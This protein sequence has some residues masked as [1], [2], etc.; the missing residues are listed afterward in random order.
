MTVIDRFSRW[1]EAVPLASATAADCAKA[2]LR[3]WVSR[4]GT[5]HDITTDQGPQFTSSLWTE[6]MSLLGIKALRTTSYHPQCNGMVERVH[7]VLKERLM[8][9]AASPSDWMQDLP[10]V[11]LGLRTS[12][13][14]DSTF[15]P[16][17]LVYGSPLRLPGEFFEPGNP[18]EVK[19]SDF[20]VQL[21]RSLKD[22]TPSK[23]EFHSSRPCGAAGVP[24][25]LTAS[26]SVFVRVDAVKRPLTPPYIG[27]FKVLEKTGKTFVLVRNNKPWTVSVD[28]LKP[29]F[30]SDMSALPVLPSPSPSSPAAA[31]PPAAPNVLPTSR[32][33][34]RLH[35]PD[36][37]VP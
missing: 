22:M 23:I 25:S 18:R 34:R 28:R 27:P 14:D 21:Q 2:L 15:T 24:A 4:F 11:L 36:R 12:A 30:Q 20:V 1:L 19:S 17:H 37:F 3:H 26:D 9:R 29:C 5:P 6:L 10:W 16:A 7:R 13:R 8:S 35:Q 33:G 32:F 31:A